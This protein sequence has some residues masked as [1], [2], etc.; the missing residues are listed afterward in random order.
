MDV[1]LINPSFNR[2]KMGPFHKYVRAMA[3]MSL[4]FLASYL[5][6]KGIKPVIYDEQIECLSEEKIKEIFGWRRRMIAGITCLTAGADR[7][8]ELAGWI[9]AANPEAKI[10]FGGV[11]ATVLPEEVIIKGGAD[12][13]V[14]NEG[15]DTLCELVKYYSEGGDIR[16]IKG[17]SFMDK[18]NLFHTP[19]RPP[20]R[21]LDDLPEFP[22]YL[23]EKNKDKYSF[24]NLLTSR[25]CP[26]EC[27]FC[28]QRSI[29][30]KTYRYR[31]AEK[32]LSE[33]DTLISIYGQKNIIFNDD[34]F[35]VNRR[36]VLEI[37]RLIIER[38]YPKNVR[39]L[40]M[41]RSDMVDPEMLRAMRKAGF[42]S[43]VF[44]LETGSER[45]MKLIKKR[46]TLEDNEKAVRMAREAGFV[47]IG[48]FILGFPTETREESLSTIRFA[49]KINLDL[50]RFNLLVPYPGTEVS[51]M[52]AKTSDKPLNN[53][54]DFLTV[55]GIGKG[56]VPYVPEGRTD[57]EMRR[58]QIW[59]NVSFYMRPRQLLI[60]ARGGYG[61]QLSIPPVY[62]MRGIKA[63]TEIFVYLAKKMMGLKA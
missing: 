59:A 14:R 41:A 31:S 8:Y 5:M 63:Y 18:G 12:I 50:N 48:A 15:E 32:V 1:I 13:V 37:C 4:G 46:S 29:S 56:R 11:H 17:I 54:Q 61:D 30:G 22:Y 23:F 57:S 58:L 43:I 26:Y 49:K 7:A 39:F 60:F 28:S 21:D 27:I 36:R 51:R 47:T 10:I 24:G 34:N 2:E 33:L 53:W 3:P 40:A 35:V 62:T 42:K 45:L 19:D 38:K 44:G 16:L 55:G 20:I 9:K 25:G 52:I 6:A